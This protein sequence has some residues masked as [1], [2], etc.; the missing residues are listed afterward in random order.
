MGRLKFWW[1]I[2]WGCPLGGPGWYTY[3]VLYTGDEL[4]PPNWLV[5]YDVD[6]YTCYLVLVAT[7]ESRRGNFV[8]TCPVSAYLKES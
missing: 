1:S 3:F 7:L 2:R 5:L 6:R 8:R 4:S